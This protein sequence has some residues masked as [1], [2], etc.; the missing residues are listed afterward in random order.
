ML[1]L[2]LVSVKLESCQVT[3]TSLGILGSYLVLIPWHMK[4]YAWHD[5]LCV[6][7]PNRVIVWLMH[8]WLLLT[9]VSDDNWSLGA[10]NLCRDW[11]WPVQWVS[12]WAFKLGPDFF[13]QLSEAARDGNRHITPMFPWIKLY[14]MRVWV[15]VCIRGYGCKFDSQLD[16]FFSQV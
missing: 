13:I 6:C 2:S 10:V 7:E 12:A 16:R 5:L 1:S 15:W 4:R 11:R 8:V 14:R 3:S 9:G